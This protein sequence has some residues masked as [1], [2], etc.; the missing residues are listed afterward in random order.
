MDNC[1]SADPNNHGDCLKG[2]DAIWIQNCAKGGWKA[3]GMDICRDFHW[4][5]FHHVSKIHFTELIPAKECE[6]I[7]FKSVISFKF[8]GFINAG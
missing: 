6:T 2:T 8:G 3:Q 1:G 7:N 4:E 5:L